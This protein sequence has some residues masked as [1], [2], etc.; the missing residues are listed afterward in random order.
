MEAHVDKWAFIQIVLIIMCMDIYMIFTFLLRLIRR[1]RF[2]FK[3]QLSFHISAVFEAIAHILNSTTSACVL[4][5]Y[6]IR[7]FGCINSLCVLLFLYGKIEY[8]NHSQILGAWSKGSWEHSIFYLILFYAIILLIINL[9]RRCN[10]EGPTCVVIKDSSAMF[11]VSSQP[12][13]FGVVAIFAVSIHIVLFYEYFKKTQ[14]LIKSVGFSSFW[15][16]NEV[17][18]R[19]WRNNITSFVTVLTNMSAFGIYYIFVQEVDMDTYSLNE[20]RDVH[21]VVYTVYYFNRY[22]NWFMIVICSPWRSFSMFHILK[23]P[24]DYFYPPED[25]QP[26]DQNIDDLPLGASAKSVHISP[27]CLD[28]ADEGGEDLLEEYIENVLSAA[29]G[30]S[31]IS[32]QS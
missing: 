32:E 6:G 24:T 28:T 2:Y 23:Q 26:Q 27:V 22:V 5:C 21:Y 11:D 9:L 25:V 31:D 10:S 29:L 13:W 7:V 3:V 17:I 4:P 18:H 14:A 15:M 30:Q 1:E 19:I 16:E 12:I 8:H 20:L